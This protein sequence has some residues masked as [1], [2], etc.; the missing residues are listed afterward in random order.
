MPFTVVSFTTVP[1]RI[2]HL[3]KVI[4]SI[5]YNQTIKPDYVVLYVPYIFKRTGE[6]YNA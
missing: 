1:S 5:Y 6:L 2:M 4:E 3:T